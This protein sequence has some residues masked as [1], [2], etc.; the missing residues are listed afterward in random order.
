M[1]KVLLSVAVFASIFA[2][3]TGCVKE[4]NKVFLEIGRAH[5]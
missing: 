4:E 1:K 5:V 3:I 2:T